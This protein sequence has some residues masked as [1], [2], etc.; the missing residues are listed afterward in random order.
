MV[1]TVEIVKYLIGDWA[2]FNWNS[3]RSSHVHDAWMFSD[4]EAMPNT[5][6]V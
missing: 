3:I 6:G 4:S 1:Y 5:S 2:N